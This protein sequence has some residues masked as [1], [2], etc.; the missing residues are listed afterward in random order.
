MH[1]KCCWS[2]LIVVTI[3]C[4]FFLVN[5]WNISTVPLF[6][7]FT[8]L[9]VLEVIF[10]YF[11]CIIY[12]LLYHKPF[13]KV[14]ENI[15]IWKGQRGITMVAIKCNPLRPTKSDKYHCY[16]PSKNWQCQFIYAERIKWKYTFGYIPAKLLTDA[17]NEGRSVKDVEESIVPYRRSNRISSSNPQSEICA[18]EIPNTLER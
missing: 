13:K 4:C 16:Q 11:Y 14:R 15:P 1:A 10:T 9:L 17:V 6:S 12:H 2:I 5:L 7:Y 8:L 3:Y 18:S